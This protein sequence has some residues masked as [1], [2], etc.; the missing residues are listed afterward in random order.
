M[1]PDSDLA[2]LDPKTTFSTHGFDTWVEPK[3][4]G[5]YPHSLNGIL[6]K[7]NAQLRISEGML[8]A[9]SNENKNLGGY[10]GQRYRVLN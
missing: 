1:I 7:H 9:R 6:T 10:P 8:R 3:S 2:N 5:G 4:F